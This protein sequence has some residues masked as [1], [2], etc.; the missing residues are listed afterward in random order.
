MIEKRQVERFDLKL[1]AY[2]VRS[3]DALKAESHRLTTRDVSM[4]G[5]YL[6]TQQPLPLGTKVKVDVILS[7]EGAKQQKIRKALIKAFGEV[8][9]TDGE[10]MAIG[11]DENSK[12]MPF[13]KED[14]EI[15]NVDHSI[16]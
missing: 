5:A 9:R 11:F 14:L 1:E 16:G 2:V 13:A 12:F 8:V 3:D 10:G 4:N 7:M 6:L 15:K